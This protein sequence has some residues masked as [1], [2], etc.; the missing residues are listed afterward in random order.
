MANIQDLL[1][2]ILSARYGEEVRGSIH[3]A[4]EQ[5]YQDGQMAATDLVARNAAAAVDIK[6][7]DLTTLTTTDK[8]NVVNA[9]NELARTPSGGNTR[10]FY[11]TCNTAP[12]T[13]A[14][15]ITCTDSNFTIEVG[16]VIAVYF[17]NTNT[18]SNVTFNVNNTGAK[19]I[20]LQNQVYTQS[21][22]YYTGAS[23]QIHMYIY[24]GSGWAWMTKS[25]DSDT[26]YSVATTSKA[27]LLPQLGGGTTNFLRADGT[28]AAPSGGSSTK[29]LL[30]TN[31]S[32][33]ANFATQTVSLNLSNY[34]KVLIKFKSCVSATEG[35]SPA[36][37]TSFYYYTDEI[38]VG[39][40]SFKVIGA[41]YP[42]ARLAQSSSTGIVFNTTAILTNGVFYE[43][44]A[45]N[46]ICVPYQIYG[47]N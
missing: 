5:C 16:T 33:T 8:S 45:Y 20:Y 1:A 38:W 40:N 7:G 9:I 29:T 35:S 23:N 32:P 37:I 2:D 47:I 12:S 41:N 34:K 6:V 18:A 14:K 4:I 39:E 44:T 46:G 19:S 30:W 28:W 25:W 21:Y 43:A 27:G 15:V 31:A 10:V 42:Y 13:A 11:C 3:D 22:Y 24:N 26:T 36:V 17:S